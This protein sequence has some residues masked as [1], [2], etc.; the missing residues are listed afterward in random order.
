M[1]HD[2]RRPVFGRIGTFRARLSYGGW[3]ERIVSLWALGRGLTVVPLSAVPADDACGPR[4]STPDGV[5]VAPDLLMLGLGGSHFVE[6]KRKSAP[7]A[8]RISGTICTGIERR[9]LDRYL[10]VAK[11]TK[12]PVDLMLVHDTGGAELLGGDVERLASLIHHEA[13][14]MVFWDVDELDVLAEADEMDELRAA[15]AGSRA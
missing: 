11:A 14:G 5:H 12:T 10:A 13:G 1:S 9:D 15:M 2:H 4:I 6:V 7:T 3:A 8:H